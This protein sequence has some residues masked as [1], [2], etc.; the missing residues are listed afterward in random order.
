MSKPFARKEWAV[1]NGRRLQLIQKR[2][3]NGELDA[4]DVAELGVLTKWVDAYVAEHSPRGE[5]AADILEYIK[6]R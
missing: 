1:K 2:V 5:L 3:N 6:D 4:A